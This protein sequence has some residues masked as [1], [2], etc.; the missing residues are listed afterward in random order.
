MPK[1]KKK[2]QKKDLDYYI[3]NFMN[4]NVRIPWNIFVKILMSHYGCEMESKRGSGR[5]FIKDDCRVTADEPHGREKFVSKKDRERIIKHLLNK[6][7]L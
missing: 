5:L 3:Q 4:Y 7:G 2:G 1:S 6:L